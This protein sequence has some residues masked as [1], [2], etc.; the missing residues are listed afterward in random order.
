MHNNT[1]SDAAPNAWSIPIFGLAVT[2]CLAVRRGTAH[3]QDFLP[4][5][6]YVSGT[7]RHVG[8]SRQK[9]RHTAALQT[10]SG[11]PVYTDS[12]ID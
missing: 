7:N 12:Q 11:T 4:R 2:Q 3:C 5:V 9:P 1:D 8:A 6:S 10:P